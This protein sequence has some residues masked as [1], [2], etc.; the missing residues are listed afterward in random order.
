MLFASEDIL[1]DLIPKLR[2][3][4][5]TFERMKK[6]LQNIEGKELELILQIFCPWLCSSTICNNKHFYTRHDISRYVLVS[7]MMLVI[8]TPTHLYRMAKF[9]SV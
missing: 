6:Q 9:W 5:E 3:P 8:E 1:D 7:R 4:E 2:N